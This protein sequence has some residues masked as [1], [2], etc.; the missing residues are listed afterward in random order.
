MPAS[1]KEGKIVD[2]V[3]WIAVIFILGLGAGLLLALKAG[4]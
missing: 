1:K 2:R 4:W 3:A